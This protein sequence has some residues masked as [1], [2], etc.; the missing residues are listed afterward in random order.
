[1]HDRIVNQQQPRLARCLDLLV[2]SSLVEVLEEAL[3]VG[4]EAG[5]GDVRAVAARRLHHAIT[6]A[7]AGARLPGVPTA[8]A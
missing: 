6:T 7:A 4:L 1:M 2:G 5:A 3:R 8:A